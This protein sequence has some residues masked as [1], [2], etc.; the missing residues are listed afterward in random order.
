[1]V[2]SIIVLGTQILNSNMRFTKF[3]NKIIAQK[4]ITKSGFGH[5]FHDLKNFGVG[6]CFT[7][8]KYIIKLR[9]PLQTFAENINLI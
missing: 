4:V 8:I 1:M 7:L 9:A 2:S 6:F 5:R 3:I